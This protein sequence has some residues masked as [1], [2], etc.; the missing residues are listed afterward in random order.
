MS[1]KQKKIR[2]SGDVNVTRRNVTN[3]LAMISAGAIGSPL[4]SRLMAAET[5]NVIGSRM[6][7]AIF[8]ESYATIALKRALRYAGEDGFVSSMPQLLHARVNAPFDNIIW[9]TWFTS[10]SEESVVTTLQGNHVVVTV[11]GGGIFAS[12]ARIER[13]LR[14]DLDRTNPEGLTGQYAAK[15]SAAEARDLLGGYLPDGSEV[16]IYPFDEFRRGI[17]NLPT[18]Y[19]VV[20]D[21]ESAKMAK[22]GYVSFEILK[23][24]PGMIIRAGGTEPLAAYLDKARG[25]NDTDLMGSW[26]PYNRIDPQQHQTRLLRLAGNK[27]G[28]GSEG[29]DDSLGWGYDSD[30]GIGTSGFIGL[31]RYVAVAPRNLSTSLQYLDFET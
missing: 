24:D 21:F 27:G 26:H 28:K 25:R 8:F 17:A 16:P 18:R 6:V 14:A 20:L 13:S 29:D 31:A 4:F 7:A 2:T 30:Y 5:S 15:I 11:H 23:E 3:V 9:N 19:A 1:K 12:P 22:N 10:N